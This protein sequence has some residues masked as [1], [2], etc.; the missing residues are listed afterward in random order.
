MP[1]LHHLLH[2]TDLDFLERVSHFWD[3]ELPLNSFDEALGML[4]SR[5]KDAQQAAQV[6]ESSPEEAKEAWN[7]L[8]EQRGRMTSAQF[9]R[10]YGEIRVM[11]VAKRKRE[12]PDLHPSSP[13]EMLWYRAL[14]GKGIFAAEGEPQEF[15]YIPDELVT[16]FA[17]PE[18]PIQALTFRPAA[19]D[20]HLFTT[21][22]N[23]EILDRL[24]V[25]LCELR[26][27]PQPPALLKS[28]RTPR[29]TFMLEL[30]KSLGM[31]GAANQIDPE[32][33]RELLEANRGLA[34]LHCYTHWLESDRI[35]DLR[36]LPGL[37]FEGNWQ[38]SPLLP[39]KILLNALTQTGPGSWWS[40][41]SL[42]AEIKSK[43]PDFQRPAGDYDSWFIRRPSDNRY[44]RG[45]DAW[46]EV[47]GYLIRYLISGPLHWLGVVDL[48]FAAK[49]QPAVCFRLSS[50]GRMLIQGISPER[51]FAANSEVKISSSGQFQ[52]PAGISMALRYQIGRFCRLEKETARETVY[53]VTGTSPAHAVDQGLKPNQLIAL[54]KRSNVTSLSP[55]FIRLVEYWE[56]FGT[57]V[58]MENTVLLRVNR[59]E[60]LDNLRKD[61]RSAR[62]LGDELTPLIVKVN[63]GSEAALVKILAESGFLTDTHLDV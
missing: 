14:I 1:D 9:S 38:N 21:P 55:A 52:L 7:G 57:A 3:F 51:A 50:A 56:K 20:E 32:K 41:P 48:G 62:C 34:L 22:A 45:F 11:G 33:I 30:L 49:N 27:D 24:A 25:L 23:D 10:E 39:R 19:D 60:V 13:A 61:S 58:Q 17:A 63:P 12:Q 43:Q 54:L 16:L 4:E 42:V 35:N 5:L 29:L 47:E 6:I 40:I 8:I 15:V 59:P 36:M 53:M 18:P 46:D 26:K 31:L 2:D 28:P 44:L 37:T